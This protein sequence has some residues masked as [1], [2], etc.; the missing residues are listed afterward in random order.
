[1]WFGLTCVL[2]GRLVCIGPGMA[3]DFG[4]LS[5]LLFCD[6]LGIVNEDFT[7]PGIML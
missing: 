5:E 4:S 2:N 3:V 7:I 6:F 1:M